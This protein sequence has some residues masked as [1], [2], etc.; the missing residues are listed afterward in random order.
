MCDTVTGQ[1][2]ILFEKFEILECLKKDTV[3]CVYLARHIFLSKKI[4]LKTLNRE[5]LKDPV[6]LERFKREAKILAK[7]DHPNVIRVLDFG[8]DHNDFYIS[9]A[10]FESRNLRQLL[11]RNV[12]RPEDKQLLFDQLIKGLAAAHSNGIVHRDIKPENILVDDGLHLKLADFG[13]AITAEENLLTAKSSI[14]G[15]PAYMSPE[16]ISGARM[17]PAS[18]LFTLGIV[19]FE[20]FCGRNP[21]LGAEINQTINNILNPDYYSLGKEIDRCGLPVSETLKRLLR[22]EGF[23]TPGSAADLIHGTAGGGGISGKSNRKKSRKQRYLL[24]PVIMILLVVSYLYLDIWDRDLSRKAVPDTPADTNVTLAADPVRDQ[25]KMEKPDTITTHDTRKATAAI[26]MGYLQVNTIPISEVW[27]DRNRSEKAMMALPQ[28]IHLIELH[29]PE[30]PVYR[31]QVSISAGETLR[32]GVRLDTLFGFCTCEAYPWG[33]VYIDG[34]HRGDTP[35][36]KP[37]RLSPGRYPIVFENP[38][39]PLYQDTVTICRNETTHVQINLE[40]LRP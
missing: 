36:L 25:S 28:G 15:T 12:L 38:D 19:A 27:I 20:L 24:V 30:F 37:V 10:Y 32:I 33:T 11:S 35:I 26:P 9:F 5:N 17:T 8:S 40:S 39:F 34:R 4:L 29:N 6:W 2:Q 21:F 13:L 22:F 23:T 16:Q 3:S 31:E 14:V 7:L 1:P 18:D